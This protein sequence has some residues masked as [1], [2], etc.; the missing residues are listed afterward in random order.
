M[1]RPFVAA[2]LASVAVLP[3]QD[4]LAILEAHCVQCHN[5]A[6]RKSDLDLTERSGLLHGGSK[7][8]AV[9]PGAPEASLLL[10]VIEHARKPFMPLRKAQLTAAE[11]AALRE[12]IA[13]GAEYARPLVVPANARAKTESGEMQVTEADRTFWSFAPLVE[14]APPAIARPERAHN[15]LDRF[16]L[17]KLDAAGIAP[18]PEADP[19]TLARR[20]YHTLVG[21][22]PTPGQLAAFLR[23]PT[24]AA[25]ERLVDELMASP[26]FG[27]RQA[28][29]WLDVARYA[30]SGGYEFDHERAH[31]WP[32]R[33]FVLEAFNRDLPF[34]EFV[35]LQV[36]ADELCPDE[37]QAWRATGFLCAGPTVDNQEN[38]QTRYDEYDDVV[39]TLGAAFLG[40][41]VGC[42]RCHDHKFDPIPTRDYYRLVAAFGTS[43]RSVRPLADAATVATWEADKREREVEA[44]ARR[45]AREALLDKGRNR[46]RARLASA[47]GL[48]AEACALLARDT[49]PERSWQFTTEAPGDQ[50][51]APSFDD[52][53]WQQGESPFG[54]G[55]DNVRIGTPWTGEEIWARRTFWWSGDASTLTFAAYHDEDVEVYVN[56]VLAA[57]GQGYTTDYVELAASAA[58]RAALRPGHN[59]LA[60]HCRQTVG[61]QLL[62]VVP[63]AP[64][65]LAEATPSAATLRAALRTCRDRLLAEHAEGLRVSDKAARA[66]LTDAEAG[67]LRE[68]GREGSPATDLPRALVMTDRA[69]T[70]AKAFLLGRGD[71]NDR[72]E[73][74]RPGFLQVIT[75]TPAQA[76]YYAEPPPKAESTGQRA[77]LAR[78]LTD[79]DGGAG[80]LLARVIVN[81]I[82]QQH[83]GRGIVGTP[84]DFGMQGDAPTHP[85]LLDW[86]ARRLLEGGWQLKP[87]HRLIVTSALYRQASALRAD[88][89]ADPSNRL[90]HRREPMRR[91]AEA[92]RDAILGVSGCL[93]RAVGGRS[94][95]PRMH[96]DAIATG[97]T[98][99]WD[100]NAKDGPATWRRSLYVFMRR[101]VRFPMLEVF[102]APDATA[103]CGRRME[104]T[105]PLQALALLNDVFVR[106]Q[107]THL[108][109]RVDADDGI[110]QLFQLSLQRAPTAIERQRARAFLA[111]QTQRHDGDRVA[112]FVDLCQVALNLNEF[113]YVD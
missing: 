109:Q 45:A 42:A 111:A 70:P 110:T 44:K 76:T 60:V 102:D 68:L 32:Y 69:S 101:S 72:R 33:D 29:W 15:D 89:A 93:N 113:L 86:L 13:A 46:E 62:D 112:A 67:E 107:A 23:T 105:T 49:D 94:V 18:S 5:P 104:T 25:Y 82:W 2:L 17:A 21:L 81:R 79:V 1:R 30:D 58:G 53:A 10:A 54:A 74:I 22:P 41:T 97:S 71:P 31:A 8:P 84:N 61:G 40:L 28:R 103:S 59:V 3:A 55:R 37:P 35:R 7:G 92:L 24:P 11:R 14:A 26:H 47:L 83:M 65:A 51:N 34:D 90:W 38:E 75:A 50:W 80:R 99:K 43:T 108:A 52:R 57:Q 56:G 4:P 106:E 63:L 100:V 95:M 48:D 87:I 77:A 73:E 98:K 16:W 66:A 85:E 36:A 27:E 91:D 64:E 39:S 9:V 96:P 12:W 88:A 20:A 6:R 19:R 78:W